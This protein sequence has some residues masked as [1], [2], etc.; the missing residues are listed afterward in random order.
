MSDIA[1]LFDK[2]S[3]RYRLHRGWYFSIRDEVTRLFR[4]AAFG[5]RRQR[6]EFWALKDV[7]FDVRRGETLGLIGANGA[8]K[9]TMLKILSRVTV[10]TTGT[11]VARGKIGSIIEIGAGFHPELSGRENVYLNGAVVGMRRREIEAKFESIVAFSGVERFIDTPIKF[12]SSGMMVRLG[13]AVAA[14]TDPDILLV[15]EVLAVGDASFQ[16]KCL[17]KLAELKESKKTIVLV[18]HQMS[19]ILQHAS[20]ALWI[21]HG[22]VRELG[23]PDRVV[24]QYLRAA[25]VA[26]PHR[27]SH[28]DLSEDAPIRV[29]E[30]VFRD[31][32]GRPTDVLEYGAVGSIDVAYEVRGLVSDPVIAVGIHDVYGQPLGI[33]TTRLDDVKLD[34][35]RERGV[36]RLVLAP[37]LFTRGAYTVSVTVFDEHIRRFLDLRSH[38]G[39]F[40]V[41]GPG[42][43]TREVWGHVVYPHRWEVEGGE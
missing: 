25:L 40:R 26:E 10:P 30:V 27:P 8:G 4:Q 11:F 1:I 33:V 21:D 14:H 2:V 12:Y 22:Q 19:N 31:G 23:D 37:V 36:V 35:T 34:T 7:S 16:A 6:D 39:T 24:E 32:Q 5:E 13:F 28:G 29:R 3:K 42:E 41:E 38:A 43:S 18:S 15:D 17:N 9:S 20:R